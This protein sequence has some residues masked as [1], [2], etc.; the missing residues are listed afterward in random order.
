M[1]K[2]LN[3]ARQMSKNL[4]N[5]WFSEIQEINLHKTFETIFELKLSNKITNTLICAIIYAYDQD[6]KWIDL[7][8]DGMTINKNILE[9]LGA[10]LNELIYN[11]FLN[12]KN[13]E[14]LD[15]IG[16]YLD[17]ISDWRFVTARKMIDYHSKYVRETE[18]N[19]DS[20]DEDKKIKARENIGKLIKESV[21]QRRTADELILQIERDY[22]NTNH[23]VDQ[24]FGEKFTDTAIKVDC[25]SWRAFIRNLKN[26]KINS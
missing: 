23:K 20:M 7:K 14:I 10:D 17:R 13:D 3:L 6:S 5:D 22:V 2:A 8:Q 16:A 9:G 12:L 15:S 21:A 25:L 26:N 18:A 1:Q 24:D 19:L 4:E 11:D